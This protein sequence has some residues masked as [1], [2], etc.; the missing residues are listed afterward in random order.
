MSTVYGNIPKLMNA[1][2]VKDNRKRKFYGD[3]GGGT[4]DNTV[5]EFLKKI[6]ELAE[7]I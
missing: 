1:E 5:I 4:V 6:P 3:V 7:K 2:I